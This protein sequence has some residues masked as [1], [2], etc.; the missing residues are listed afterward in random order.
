MKKNGDGVERKKKTIFF[1]R[2]PKT[3]SLDPE[4][5]GSLVFICKQRFGNFASNLVSIY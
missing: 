4:R 5:K 1:V 3:K 2:M